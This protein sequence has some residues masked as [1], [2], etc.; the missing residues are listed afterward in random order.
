MKTKLGG[1]VLI[2]IILAE[3]FG[4][5][6][7]SSFLPQ[8]QLAKLRGEAYVGT[9]MS[10]DETFVVSIYNGSSWCIEE[11]FVEVFV[12]G[13][14]RKFQLTN[15]RLTDAEFYPNGGIK[16]FGKPVKDICQPLSHAYYSVDVGRFVQAATPRNQW[17]W[18]IV[19]ARGYRE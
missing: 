12:R 2:A 13:E 11:L 5:S 1:Y 4:C 8:D 15:W 6:R 19:A 18:Q 16:T 14:S 10:N 3:V 7:S 9:T 17:S